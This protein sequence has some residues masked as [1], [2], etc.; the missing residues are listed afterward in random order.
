MNKP[1]ISVV[2]PTYNSEKYIG[3]CIDS[4]LAQTYKHWELIIIDDGS[5]DDTFCILEKY[6]KEDCRV[7]IIHQENQGPGIARNTGIA[8]AKGEY[9]VF[10]DSDDYIENDYFELLAKHDEDV[11]FI[12]VQNVDEQGNV[13]K[14]DFMSSNRTLPK[15]TIIRRQMTGRL[16]WGGYAR[17]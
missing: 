9:I 8:A 3:K 12:D 17:P 1:T 4:I 15:D 10:I 14:K 2:V 13:I 5:Q 6:A 11:V 16:N 7:H